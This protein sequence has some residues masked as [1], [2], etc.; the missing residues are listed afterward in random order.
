MSKEKCK[1]LTVS[2]PASMAEDIKAQG[3]SPSTFF[4]TAWRNR[5]GPDNK[6]RALQDKAIALSFQTLAKALGDDLGPMGDFWKKFEGVKF[7]DSTKI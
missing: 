4:Q 1:I 6:P 2:V 3:I 5:L 7:V